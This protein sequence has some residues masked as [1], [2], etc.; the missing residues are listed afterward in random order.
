MKKRI[1][2]AVAMLLALIIL[3]PVSAFAA[4]SHTHN[5]NDISELDS[6]YSYGTVFWSDKS[7][8]LLTLGNTASK[9][10]VSSPSNHYIDA[11]NGEVIEARLTSCAVDEKGNICDVIL[12]VDNISPFSEANQNSKDALAERYNDLSANKEDF[13]RADLNVKK[14]TDSDLMLIWFRTNSSGADFTMKYVLSGTDKPADINGTVA[15][16]YD[17]DVQK[18]DKVGEIWNGNE[19]FTA[20]GS[21]AEIYYLKNNWLIDTPDGKGVRCPDYSAGEKNF[22]DTNSLIPQNSAVVAESFD[23]ATF[24]LFYSGYSCGIAYSFA[25]PYPFTVDNPTKSVDKAEAYEG[26]T[27]EYTVSQYIPNSYYSSKLNFIENIESWSS[28]EIKDKFDESLIINPDTV[29]IRNELGADASEYFAISVNSDN[30]VTAKAT[31]DALKSVDFYSHVYTLRIKAV[32]KEGAGLNKSIISNNAVTLLNQT[33]YKSNTVKTNLIFKIDTSITNGT[34]TPS[35]NSIAGGESKQIDFAPDKDCYVSSVTVDGQSIDSEHYK[36]GGIYS[37]SSINA[38]HSIEVVCTP[39][40]W[41]NINIIYVDEN[42][43][44]LAEPFNQSVRAETS[45]DVTGTANRDIQYYTLESIEGMTSGTVTGDVNIIVRY[46]RN[47]NTVTINYL[48][49]ETDEKLAESF[50]QTAPQG[51]EY[52]LSEQ[53]NK[54]IEHYTLD[55][56]D[57]DTIG[58]LTEDIYINVYYIKNSGKVIVKYVDTEG[59]ELAAS[60]SFEGKVQDEYITEAKSINDYELTETPDNSTGTFTEDDITVIYVYEKIKQPQQSTTVNPDKPTTTHKPETETTTTKKATETTKPAKEIK[61]PNTGNDDINYHSYEL[62]AVI[63]IASFS[64]V[65]IIFVSKSGKR[66]DD[67]NG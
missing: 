66:K 34:I 48:D 37:F 24:R 11:K 33:E 46:V 35:I 56:I 53:A 12:R 31:S 21:D 63:L 17:I 26:D 1:T 41:Y 5:Y 45:Y 15:T 29:N 27:L 9:H 16:I 38:N 57:S 19:G 28:L 6:K 43:N 7:E 61:S 50:T 8:L 18:E 30:T 10:L 2:K 51:T 36:N 59:N 58:V 4:V 44:A 55:S 49:K 22:E 3:I 60:E 64:S 39:Y 25:S 14:Y 42:D 23:D 54:T 67:S 62:M 40:K 52:D 13:L 20:A 65:I 47:K 32:I